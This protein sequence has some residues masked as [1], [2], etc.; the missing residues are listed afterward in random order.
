MRRTSGGM[1]VVWRLESERLD[2]R[3]DFGGYVTNTVG[4]D[5]R[6]GQEG[7]VSGWSAGGW[8]GS[9]LHIIEGGKTLLVEAT[10]CNLPTFFNQF[11]LTNVRLNVAGVQVE[12]EVNQDDRNAA[13]ESYVEM[14]TRIVTQPLPADAGDE[15]TALDSVYSAVCDDPRNRAP[16][17]SGDN[18]IQQ[19]CHPCPEPGGPSFYGG[20]ASQKPSESVR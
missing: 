20:M 11:N 18:S 17:G 10:R 8:R 14:L 3:L 12:V 13:W 1:W 15:Q 19:G 6:W 9:K 4:E 2:V 5:E 7:G 16:E